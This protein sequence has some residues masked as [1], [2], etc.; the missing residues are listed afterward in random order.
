MRKC[1]KN[2]GLGTVNCVHHTLVAVVKM[3]N[4]LLLPREEKR[5]APC[6]ETAVIAR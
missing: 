2:V 6:R 5:H 3:M 4:V 1:E